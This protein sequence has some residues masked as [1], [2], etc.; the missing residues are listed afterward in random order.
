MTPLDSRWEPGG[1][2]A[3]HFLRA[4]Q[5]AQIVA[6]SESRRLTGLS[7]NFAVMVPITEARS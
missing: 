2:P 7:P 5:A 4:D 6:C 3:S 1:L